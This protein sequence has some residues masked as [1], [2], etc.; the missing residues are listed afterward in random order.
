MIEIKEKEK[1]C[2]CG[3]CVTV[4]PQKCISF[5]EDANGFWYP[6]VDKEKC[7]HCNMCEK[8]CSILQKKKEEQKDITAFAA[9]ALNEDIR[10]KS[11]SGGLF[12]LLA[13]K[14]LDEGG[15]VFG[16]AFDEEFMV[17]HIAITKKAELEKL[18]GSK[19]LQSRIENTFE[20]TKN[21]LEQGERVLFSGMACQIAGLKR[22]LGKE[23]ANLITVDILCHGVP[24]PKIWR[25]YLDEQKESGSS[26][27]QIYFRNK[28]FGWKKFSLKIVFEPLKIYRKQ[29]YF[30]S[31]MRLFMSNICFRESCYACEFKDLK[32]PS[33][34]TLG[35]CWGIENYMPDMD[36]DKGTS[37]VLIHS[38]AGKKLF[39]TICGDL[40]VREAEIE[41]ILPESSDSRKSVKPHPK[42]EEF[43]KQFGQGKKCSELVKLIDD[44]LKTK[45]K[46]KIGKIIRRNR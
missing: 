16:A 35:D 46:R 43:F 11:S 15:V 4:C 42:R 3:A 21:I 41:K 25:R 5:K 13:E 2:G 18:R 19:Y 29:F 24:S 32:R 26:V 36:D 34:I 1:C 38:I 23:Y 12:T 31:F 28:H 20:E 30:D 37:L 8:V 17:H 33:D 14:V 7:I 40:E 44:S 39:Q 6:E 22:Y 27:K 10:V 9:Y 45:V